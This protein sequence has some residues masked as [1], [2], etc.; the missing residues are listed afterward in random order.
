MLIVKNRLDG[1]CMNQIKIEQ[2]FDAPIDEVFELLSKH[3]TYNIAFAPIQVKRVK[4]AA[5]PTRPDGL[6]SIRRMGFGPIKPIQEKITHLTP[7][8]RIEYKLIKNP[9]IRHHLGI[10]QFQA[11]SEQSTQVTYIIELDARIPFLS[12][13]ILA[14]LKVAIKLGFKKLA[15]SYKH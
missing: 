3:E 9:L 14:Q 10:I 6:G 1:N 12:Q 13:L 11:L 8:E 4:D 7:N 5:D 2:K 15:K